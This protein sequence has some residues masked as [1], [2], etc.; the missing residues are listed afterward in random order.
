MSAPAET[1]D[2]TGSAPV[3]PTEDT[4]ARRTSQGTKRKSTSNIE[5]E[6]VDLS[7]IDIDGILTQHHLDLLALLGRV[8]R[9]SRSKMPFKPIVTT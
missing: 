3:P 8:D 6:D 9:S 2:L 5:E 7:D 1:I 4:T